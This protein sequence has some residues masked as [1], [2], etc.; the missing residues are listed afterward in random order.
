MS[1]NCPIPE[2]HTVTC[3]LNFGPI[4]GPQA[5]KPLKQ[6]E[7][8][9]LAVSKAFIGPCNRGDGATVGQSGVPHLC[10]EGKR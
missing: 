5:C 4:I 2:N 10:G 3:V 6:P 9:T 8:S 1:V 7:K